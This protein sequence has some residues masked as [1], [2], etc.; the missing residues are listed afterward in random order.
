MWLDK[1][2]QLNKVWKVSG[3]KPPALANRPKLSPQYALLVGVYREI[4]STERTYIE[5]HPRPLT[6][7]A[8][9]TYWRV[10]GIGED[11][12]FND[13]WETIRLIDY[14]W[15]AQVTADEKRRQD[16]KPKA[17]KAPRKR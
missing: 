15:L 1:I 3:R 6:L 11:V 13:F 17:A 9:H 16:S 14:T 10:F 12:P 7:N 5:G 4:A 2:P 8:V